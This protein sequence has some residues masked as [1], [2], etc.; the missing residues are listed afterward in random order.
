MKDDIE[1]ENSAVTSVQVDEKSIDYRD[2]DAALS[3]L[4]ANA[5]TGQ[6]V[7]I[8][9]NKLMRK[10]DWMMMPLMFACYYLQYTDKTL[11]AFSF[12]NPEIFDSPSDMCLVNYA[13]VMGLI[14]D[15]HL[16]A[17]GFSNLAIAFYVS[18]LVCEPL[19]AM[20]IQKFPTAKYLGCNGECLIL[21]IRG[22]TWVLT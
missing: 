11:R 17:N 3:F 6:S 19:Q 8:D 13:A 12:P 5:D 22:V 4:R 7:D 2:V 14:E 16:P 21:Y 15:T 10:V 1:L 9:E 18:F 20:L